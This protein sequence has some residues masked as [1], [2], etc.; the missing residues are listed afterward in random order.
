M[1]P[2]LAVAIALL[3][4]FCFGLLT[5]ALWEASQRVSESALRNAAVFANREIDAIRLHILERYPSG[6][7]DLC[8]LESR[9]YEV[10][11]LVSAVIRAT[12]NLSRDPSL[13]DEVIEPRRG[14]VRHCDLKAPGAWKVLSPRPSVFVGCGGWI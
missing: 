14:W 1:I 3:I 6:R 2:Y 5:R 9:C 11:S 4:G 12:A 7:L 10:R 13:G 8:P